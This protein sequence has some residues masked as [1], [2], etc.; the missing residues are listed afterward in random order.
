MIQMWDLDVQR[1]LPGG[2]MVDIGYVGSHG[3][4][5]AGDTFRNYNYVPTAD[6]LQYQNQLNQKCR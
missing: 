1:E 3:T 5:L 4:H 6:K 2:M